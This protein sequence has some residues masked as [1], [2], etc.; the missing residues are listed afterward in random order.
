[1]VWED[2]RMADPTIPIPTELRRP[3]PF[4]TATRQAAATAS[5]LEDGRIAVGGREGVVWITVSRQQLRRALLVAQAIFKEAERRG[6]EVKAVKKSSYGHHAGAAIAIRGHAYAIEIT[7]LH[8]K[9]P[10]TAD[11]LAD[12]DRR[13]AKK[14]YYEWQK[15]PERPTTKKVPNGYLRI[16]LPSSWNGSRNN[17]SEGPRGGIE[18]RLPTLFEEL[19]RRADADDRRAE[20][21]RRQEE[22]RHRQEVERA[23]RD[24]MLRSESA[25]VDRLTSEIAAWRLATATRDYVAAL[26]QRLPALSGEDA[27]RVRAWCDWASS[28]SD[29]T[30]PV[31]NVDLV[32][33]LDEEGGQGQFS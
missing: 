1:M 25:R 7:E 15:R 13:E 23:E 31:A 3:H 4:V 14:K 29:R 9:V 11:E 17:F 2:R 30:D 12:W 32:R 6:Y 27:A 21:R 18:R 19:E 5:Q 24:R 8:D 16:S 28:W 33:G 10:L 20:E 26:R 22:E